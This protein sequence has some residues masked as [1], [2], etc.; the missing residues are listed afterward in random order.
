MYD[1]KLA[2]AS[3]RYK[4]IFFPRFPADIYK[5]KSKFIAILATKFSTL[6]KQSFSTGI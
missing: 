2:D 1:I 6:K 3:L 5:K 4:F